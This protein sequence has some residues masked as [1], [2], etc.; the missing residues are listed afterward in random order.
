MSEPTADEFMNNVATRYEHLSAY[1]DDC[2][3]CADLIM[4]R[5]I[6]SQSDQI[7]YG[8]FKVTAD[9]I[10][11]TLDTLSGYKEPGAEYSVYKVLNSIPKTKEQLIALGGKP[12][13]KEDK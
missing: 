12:L 9:L 8:K 11:E 10:T 2:Q 1:R 5:G 3:S 7:K 4:K 13:E 6:H